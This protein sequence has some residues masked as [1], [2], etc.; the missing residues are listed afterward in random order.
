MDDC[1]ASS[2][3]C[4]LVTGGAFILFAHLS[5]LVYFMFELHKNDL[6]FVCYIGLGVIFVF[7]LIYGDFKHTL[8]LKN[9]TPDIFSNNSNNHRLMSIHFCTKNGRIIRT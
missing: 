6:S 4:Y 2:I 3:S 9:R 7:W 8:C 1:P 5:M